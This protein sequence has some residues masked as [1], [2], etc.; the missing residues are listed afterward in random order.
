MNF[1]QGHEQGLQQLW[2]SDGKLWA[3][4]EAR[5]GRNYGLVGVKGC[6]TLWKDDVH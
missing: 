6:A 3:N 5:N 2:Q 1:H 4:Y